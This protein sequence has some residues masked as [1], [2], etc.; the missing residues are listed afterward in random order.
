M[1]ANRFA[2]FFKGTWDATIYTEGFTTLDGQ[3]IDINT[4]IAHPTLDP[5]YVKIMDFVEGTFDA[6]KQISPIELAELTE[7]ESQLAQ[8]IVHSF[9]KA[10]PCHGLEIELTDIEFWSTYGF[11]FASKIRAGVALTQFRQLGD[12][13]GQGQAVH[14]LKAALVHWQTMVDLAERYNVQTIPYQF[15]P[16]FS[17]RKHS[18]DVEADIEIARRNIVSG[19][20]IDLR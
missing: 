8:D 19:A 1:N 11:Y 14:Y 16:E 9:R 20:R 5:F 12:E 7:Y 17:W 3:F 4:F 18:V 2:S 13:A 6:D 10:E 15:D